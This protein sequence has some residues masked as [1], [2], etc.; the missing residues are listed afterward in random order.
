ML[1]GEKMINLKC[2][3]CD[4]FVN[5]KN[6]SF[7]S[8]AFL[9]K[10]TMANINYCPFCGA[11][12]KYLKEDPSE[13]LLHYEVLDEKALIIID[14]AV[15]LEVFNAEFY[16]KAA[17]LSENYDLKK[18]F[19]ALSRIEMTHAKIHRKIG[20]FKELPSLRQLDYTKYTEFELLD[21]AVKREEHAVSYYNKYYNDIKSTNIK[22]IFD[23][24]KEVE[25]DH[26]ALNQYKKSE[27]YKN[28]EGIL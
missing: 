7:N 8:E 19:S 11:D 27:I 28:K 26:I 13:N 15:K 3:I 4:M 9:V 6:Y 14:H 25:T 1:R 18:L 17:E 12:I 20:G 16:A 21:M 5:E 23:S 22:K 10:N 24:L 2:I